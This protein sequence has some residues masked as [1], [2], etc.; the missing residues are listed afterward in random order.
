M[1]EDLIQAP[2]QDARDAEF[3]G[4]V[5]LTRAVWEDCVAWDEAATRYT[6]YTGDE[7]RRLWDVLWVA[8]LARGRVPLCATKIPFEV[9]RIARDAQAPEGHFVN[10]SSVRLLLTIMQERYM[11]AHLDEN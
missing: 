7:R 9:V 3:D 6:G 11:I 10:G 1:A 5:F 8:L 2:V 4:P